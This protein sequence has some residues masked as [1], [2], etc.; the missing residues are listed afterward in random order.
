VP[1]LY[2]ASAWASGHGVD[3]VIR[4]GMT[5]ARLILNRQG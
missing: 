2:L 5:A 3:S 4:G 1:G